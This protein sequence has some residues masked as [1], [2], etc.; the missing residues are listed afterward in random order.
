VLKNAQSEKILEKG[1]CALSSFCKDKTFKDSE[2]V[3]IAIITLCEIV[4]QQ[5]KETKVRSKILETLILLSENEKKIQTILESGVCP[6]LL[7]DLK[8]LKCDLCF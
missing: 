6:C 1:T 7:G 3:K 2:A 4:K 8:Y 5:T